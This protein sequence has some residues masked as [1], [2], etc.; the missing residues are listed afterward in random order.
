VVCGECVL[1]EQIWAR[2]W[3]WLAPAGEDGPVIFGSPEQ[4][5]VRDAELSDAA[6]VLKM[7]NELDQETRF[8][9]LEPGERALDVA[10]FAG[11]LADLRLREDCYLVA[12]RAGEVLGFTHAERG[13]YRRNRHSANV[14]MG[15][16]PQ[17]RGQ[18]LGTKFLREIDLWAKRFSVTRLELTVMAHNTA[19]IRL[20]AKHGY[21]AEGV[22]RASLI[23]DGEPVDELVMAKI[24][25]TSNES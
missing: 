8:M 20:Y 25:G 10:R 11:W 3:T 12:V 18:G 9:M 1:G 13:L 7:L 4:V 23:V 15:L 24:L 5:R 6:A 14:V 2:W 22:R 21:A 19:A 16:L 17:A